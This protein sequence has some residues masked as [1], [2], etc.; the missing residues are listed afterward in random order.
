LEFV[1]KFDEI[2][3]SICK[4]ILMKVPKFIDGVIDSIP[5]QKKGCVGNFF[6]SVCL[7]FFGTLFA[8]YCNCPAVKDG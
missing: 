5:Q 7:D 8:S 1:K 6:L 2:E 4:A 3:K